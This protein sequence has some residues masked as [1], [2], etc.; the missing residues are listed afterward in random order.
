[1]KDTFR[2][3]RKCGKPISIIQSRAYRKVLVDADP[4]WIIAEDL[5]EEFLRIDGSKVRGREARLDRI[6][7]LLAKP[8]YRPH[9][10]TCGAEE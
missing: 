8:A 1:M 4:V 10:K 2:L 5:G 6:E 3:C 7:D 9:N